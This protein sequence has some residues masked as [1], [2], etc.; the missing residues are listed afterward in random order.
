M[1]FSQEHFLKIGV[2]T[3][4][5]SNQIIAIVEKD[6]KKTERVSLVYV[7][8]INNQ[9]KYIGKTIQGYQRP[10]SYLK[11]NVMKDVQQGIIKEV[12]NGNLVEIYARRFGDSY[13][14]E[15]LTL[16]LCE[17]YEQALIKKYKPCWNKT[18][19]KKIRLVGI[20]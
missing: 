20:N 5:N 18:H 13:A 10:L 14:F 15:D 17:A 4:N 2:Y 16:D 19:S 9:C 11:N 1:I 6:I 8:L 7:F 3:K 12:E